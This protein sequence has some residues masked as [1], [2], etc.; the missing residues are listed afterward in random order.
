MGGSLGVPWGPRAL[1]GGALG[2]SWETL[3]ATLGTLGNPWGV[4]GELL[5]RFWVPKS[6]QKLESIDLKIDEKPLVLIAYLRLWVIKRRQRK[7]SKTKPNTGDII[8]SRGGDFGSP[9]GHLGDH[10]VVLERP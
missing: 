5:G 7:R 1:L 6:M 9:W 8:E 2:A 10:S 4:P 3:G